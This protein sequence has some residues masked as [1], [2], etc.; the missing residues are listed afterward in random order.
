MVELKPGDN[1]SLKGGTSAK[2]IKELG[3]GGQG[4]VYLVEL[5]GTK[6]ALKWYIHAPSDVFYKNLEENK[7]FANRCLITFIVIFVLI[8][9]CCKTCSFI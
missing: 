1:I 6:M 2:V 4:I 8:I 9:G 3:R 5:G 7:K